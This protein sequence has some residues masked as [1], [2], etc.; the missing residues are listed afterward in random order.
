MRA[1][2]KIEHEVLRGDYKG[3][4]IRS[5]SAADAPLYRAFD[6]LLA[7]GC[8]RRGPYS[9]DGAG[10]HVVTDLGR[11]ALR[12]ARPEMGMGLP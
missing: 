7:R 3:R 10:T 5:D 9:E 4:V 8:V 6:S 2:S 11:L 12:V 1:L